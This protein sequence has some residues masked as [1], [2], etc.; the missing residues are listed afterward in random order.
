MTSWSWVSSLLESDRLCQKEIRSFIS[1]LIDPKDR[2]KVRLARNKNGK[3]SDRP[4]TLDGGYQ[5]ELGKWKPGEKGNNIYRFAEALEFID[6]LP[7]RWKTCRPLFDR[8]GLTDPIDPRKIDQRIWKRMEKLRKSVEEEIGLNQ[9]DPGYCDAFVPLFHKRG[10]PH[11]LEGGLCFGY[12]KRSSGRFPLEVPANRAFE[13][14][15]NDEFEWG[16]CSTTTYKQLAS[17]EFLGIQCGVHAFANY[18]KHH[19]ASHVFAAYK[20]LDL[21]PGHIGRSLSQAKKRMGKTIISAEYKPLTHRQLVGIYYQNLTVSADKLITAGEKVAVDL[22]STGKMAVLI[23]PESSSA[24]KK[25]A[26]PLL[27]K[28]D[29]D[30]AIKEYRQALKLRIN[31]PAARIMLGMALSGKKNIGSEKYKK[32]PE[33]NRSDPLYHFELG[34]DLY[35]NGDIPGAIRAYLRAL[36]LNE[37]FPDAYFHL[38]I[39]LRKKGLYEEADKHFKRFKEL[40]KK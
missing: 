16:Q 4:F 1:G 8:I 19:E 33:L 13:A 28:G 37:K 35:N 23:D 14:C 17:Y 6:R 9:E 26:D 38:G 31:F 12:P 7:N 3:K 2:Y 21:D 36:K 11:F 39:A 34:K 27:E 10:L 29:R 5:T 32:S 22:V 40:Q 20:E 18:Y 15:V 24:H 30:G 25:L